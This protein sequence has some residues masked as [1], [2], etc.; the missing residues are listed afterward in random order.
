MKNL[1]KSL[2]LLSFVAL[3]IVAVSCGGGKN[4]KDAKAELTEKGKLLTSISWKLDPNATLKGT[5]DVIKD[6][7]SITANLELKGDVK[8]MADFIAETVVF[9]IDKK[10]P[11][12]LS[13]SRTIGEGFLS[14]SVLGFWNFNESETAIIMREWD[15]QLGKEKE[16]VTYNIV[17]L[18]AEKLVIQKEGDASPNIYF[19]K[20]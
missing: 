6:T 3:F 16:P 2:T 5:T 11:S 1:S 8:A 18:T 15:S 14:S 12:K 17:E 20:K 19:P 7:T 10:D 9:G 4:S 13:Y